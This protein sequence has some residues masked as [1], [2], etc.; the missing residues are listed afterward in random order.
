MMNRSI[1]MAGLLFMLIS[2]TGVPPGWTQQDFKFDQYSSQVEKYWKKKIQTNP[3][4][5]RAY[6]H[7]GRYYEF[8]RRIQLA[9]ESYR[10]ATLI[11][12]GWPQAFF[13]LGKAYRELRRFQE[14]V[15]CPPKTDPH[16]KLEKWINGRQ[17]DG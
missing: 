10:Q 11:V 6:Y 14:A 16:V 12:P 5:G 4:D 2:S 3:R 15:T 13:Y 9:A 1:A 17:G 7:L 8:T